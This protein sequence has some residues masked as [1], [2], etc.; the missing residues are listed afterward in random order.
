MRAISAN[1]VEGF[2]PPEKLLTVRW[3]QWFC[4]GIPLSGIIYDK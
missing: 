3:C 1:K 2:P 4:Q